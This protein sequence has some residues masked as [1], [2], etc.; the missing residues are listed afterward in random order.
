MAYENRPAI[1]EKKAEMAAI[2]CAV[3][4]HSLKKKK[5]VIF[6]FYNRLLGSANLLNTALEENK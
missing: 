4:T 3:F 6:R 1:R 5:K 2:F